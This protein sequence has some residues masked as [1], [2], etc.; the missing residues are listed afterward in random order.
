MPGEGRGMGKGLKRGDKIKS[1]FLTLNENF[2]EAR[3][4]Y[5]QE[6]ISKLQ[7]ESQLLKGIKMRPDEMRPFLDFVK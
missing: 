6:N 3:V 5:Q 4:T 2:N 7:S 1:C